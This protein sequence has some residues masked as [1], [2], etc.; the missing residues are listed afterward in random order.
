MK[1]RVIIREF[2]RGWGN[3]IN[4]IKEFDTQQEAL[5]FCKDFNSVNNKDYIPDWYMKAEIV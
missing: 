1:T 3:K 5:D 4:E 2:E